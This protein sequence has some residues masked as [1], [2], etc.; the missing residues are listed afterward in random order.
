MADDQHRMRI[1]REEV[2]EPDRAFEVEIVGRLVEQQHV[3][4]REQHRR[5]RHPHPPAAGELRAGP[6]L[7]RR[8]EPEP[9]QDRRRPRLRRMRVDVG[10]PRVDLGDAVRVVAPSPPRPSAPRARCRPPARCRSGCRGS[11]APPAPPRRSAPAAA[12][13]SRRRRAPARRG[14]A[15]TAWSCRCRCARRIP[16]CAPPG[17]APRHRRRA[18][19]PRCEKLMF[20][21]A[22]MRADVA[23]RRRACQPSRPADRAAQG[24]GP[25]GCYVTSWIACRSSPVASACARRPF[26]WA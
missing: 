25:G 23:R 2:L 5:Q 1:A 14:S 4:P 12:P 17:S 13:R 18:S 26:L 24:V 19:C 6:R 20:L 3:R 7:R 21:N 16:P 15:G 10:E 8:I 9:V 22:S 11:P